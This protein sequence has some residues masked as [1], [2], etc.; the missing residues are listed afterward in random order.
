MLRDAGRYIP[1]PIHGCDEF[2]ARQRKRTKKIPGKKKDQGKKDES[3]EKR[4]G[5]SDA[6]HKKKDVMLQF[7]LI[8][9]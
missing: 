5:L 9:A 6:A 1:N 7:R 3:A 8:C 2:R 4:M